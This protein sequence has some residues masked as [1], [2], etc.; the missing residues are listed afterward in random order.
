[1]TNEELYAELRDRSAHWQN[2]AE[3]RGGWVETLQRALNIRFDLERGRRD[4]SYNNIIIEFKDK[5]FFNG[6]VDSAKFKEAMDDRLAKYIP[7]TAR[8]EG[9]DPSDYIGIATD[10]NHLAFAQWIGGRLVPGP[11]LPLSP[12]SVGLVADAIRANYRRAVT[13]TNLTEDFGPHSP[14]GMAVMQQLAA[15]LST[16]LADPAGN[17][18]T[19]LFQEWRTL[20]GQISDAAQRKAAATQGLLRFR[21]V[22]SADLLIPA[23]LFIIHTYNSLL[24]KLLAAEIVASHGLTAYPFF[25]QNAL[26]Q[27]DLAGL[28]KSDVEDGRYFNDAGI[29]GFVE[30]AIFSWYLTAF[31]EPIIGS[32]LLASV[33]ALLARLSLYRTDKLETAQATD[34][35]KTFYQHLV[36]DVLRKSLGEYYTPDWLIKFSVD[37]VE[38][39]SW[40]GVRVLDPT[41]GSGS[42]LLEIIRRKRVAAAADGLSSRDLLR[43]L[44]TTV[45][46]FDLNPLAVQTARVNYLI[47]IAD[48]LT[49][50]PGHELEVPVLLADAVYSPARQPHE[51]E[52]IVRYR[53]GSEVADLEVVLPATLALDRSRLDKVFTVLGAQVERNQEP[54][55]ALQALVTRRAISADELLAWT[56][57]LSQTYTNVLALHRRHWNGIWFRIVRNFFWSATAGQFDIVVGNPPWVRWANLPPLYRER[58]KPTCEQYDIFSSTPF[59]GGNTLDISGLITYTVADK[60][61]RSEGKLVFVLTQTLFQNPSSEGFRR[62]RI[63]AGE[64]LLPL[65]VDDLKALKPFADAA[66]STA[67]AVFQKTL[68]SRNPYPV[69]YR[70]WDRSETFSRTIPEKLTLTQVLARVEQT[71]MEA[72]PVGG[73]GS[74]WAILPPGRHHHLDRLQ[75]RCDWVQGRKG[76]TAD[77]NGIYFV[78]VLAENEE[79]ERVQIE[80]RPEAGKTDLGPKRRFWVEPDLLYP[81]LKGASDIG[82]CR[83]TRAHNLFVFVPNNGILRQHY[84]AARDHV[85]TDLP[86]TLRYFEQYETLLARRSTYRGRMPN[87]PFYAIYNVGNYTFAPWKVVWAEQGKFG[88]AVIG[89]ASVPL[90]GEKPFVPDHKLFFADF[91]EPAPAYYLCGL[92]N[93]ASVKEYIES[94]N[95][96]IQL[97]DVFKHLTLPEFDSMNTRH[98]KL[99]DLARQTH[100]CTELEY[101]QMLAKVRELADTI[102]LEL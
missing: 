94:H 57:P 74:P 62:F 18:A 8:Q 86:L 73:A 21:V 96:S 15:L 2:E 67:V 102:L 54:I 42:F 3:L 19:M 30:E 60:W 25:S 99:S 35:L 82:P 11:L 9:L 101:P 52:D 45:W 72:Y 43:E 61:L 34:V 14:V 63:N 36:P 27:E 64:E 89:A 100:S 29:K 47:A 83:L 59:S 31:E 65:E 7:R 28:L 85:E 5:G 4:S 6:S 38:P 77:L 1:M 50:N 12:T 17:K 76:I 51:T 92:L 66:N 75:G 26:A 58:V 33:R 24:M 10:G 78:P 98:I 48:L 22:A 87:A 81:L 55:A 88:A 13:S 46:G 40:L 20:Y 95:I 71:E 91:Y 32:P 56:G 80:T 16:A 84:A 39:A 49:D 70:V 79:L 23:S 97:G 90:Q 69:P 68:I 53:V 37:K 44:T 93:A 41:C